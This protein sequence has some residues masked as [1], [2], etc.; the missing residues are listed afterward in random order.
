MLVTQETNSWR[1]NHQDMSGFCKENTDKV[2]RCV[3]D[4]PV[5]IGLNSSGFSL[6][7]QGCNFHT[8]AHQ[9]CCCNRNRNL[10]RKQ[11]TSRRKQKTALSGGE[12]WPQPKWHSAKSAPSF[13]STKSGTST[14]I[15]RILLWVIHLFLKAET[16]LVF[17][18]SVNTRHFW[19]Q[20]GNWVRAIINQSRSVMTMI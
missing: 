19:D 14:V 13:S 2:P 17:F 8:V 10:K 12:R 6:W 7:P 4:T 9:R 3:S 11:V 5:L 20:C 18:F 15:S 1:K 16:F